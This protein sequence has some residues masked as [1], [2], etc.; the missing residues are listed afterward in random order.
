MSEV[1]TK[2]S[3][4]SSGGSSGLVGYFKDSVVELK[5]VHTPTRSETIQA[6]LV[7]IIIMIFISVTLAIFDLIFG[8]LTAAILT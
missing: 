5:K 4:P 8:R 1:N 2:S 6:T 7:T 3:E